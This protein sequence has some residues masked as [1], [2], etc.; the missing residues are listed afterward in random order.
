MVLD[1]KV[2]YETTSASARTSSPCAASVTFSHVI[3]A[4][5]SGV[6]CCL[7][8]SGQLNSDLRRLA[9]NLIPFPRLHFFMI[10]DAKNMM[11]IVDPRHGCYLTA[12]AMFCDKMSNREVDEQMLNVPNNDSY[13]VDS[14]SNNVQSTDDEAMH[15]LMEHTCAV[16]KWT[17]RLRGRNF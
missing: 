7:C 4:T 5:M 2:L 15:F 6:T 1:K 11:C 3:S 14:I 16:Y 12:S 13:F 17:I 10:W 9:V 8:F